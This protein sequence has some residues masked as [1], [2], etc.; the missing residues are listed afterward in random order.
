MEQHTL[1]ALRNL[2]EHIQNFSWVRERLFLRTVNWEREEENL[3]DAVYRK[4]G[5]IALAVYLHIGECEEYV[6]NTRVRR[7]YLDRWGQTED[8]LFCLSMENTVQRYPARILS[9]EKFMR[10]GDWNPEGEDPFTEWTDADQGPQGNCLTTLQKSYGAIA[11]FYPGMAERL[12]EVFGCDLLLAFTSV[13][14]VMIHRMNLVLPEEVE[15]AL[16]QTLEECTPKED[17]LTDKLYYYSR[18][19]K[20]IALYEEGTS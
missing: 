17:F 8:A 2:G 16:R 12:A 20:Q 19:T 11:L 9:W 10:G 14:E 4:S 5:E 13:H 3:R 15:G 1:E 7:C 18:S 6:M